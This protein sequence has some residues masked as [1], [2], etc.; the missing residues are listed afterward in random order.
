MNNT[1]IVDLLESIRRADL[2]KITP[3]ELLVELNSHDTATHCR[4]FLND[5]ELGRLLVWYKTNW[6]NSVYEFNEKGK[7]QGIQPGCDFI[8]DKLNGFFDTVLSHRQE[9]ARK[10]HQQAEEMAYKEKRAKEAMIAA[11]AEK[12]GSKE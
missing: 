10:K 9:E 6:Y 7:I 1:Q 3:P 2:R 5:E 4:I 8:K 11:F 12:Y